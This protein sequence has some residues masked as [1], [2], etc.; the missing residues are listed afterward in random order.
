RTFCVP[1]G[2]FSWRRVAKTDN[3]VCEM[4]YVVHE[5]FRTLQ[6]EGAQAGTPMV[7]V[8]FAGCNLWSGRAADRARDA[9]RT[10]AACP[11]YCDTEFV[12]GDKLDV[13]SLIERIGALPGPGWICFTG[14]EPALQLD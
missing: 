7:F 2:G 12:S 10:G 13:P 1:A 11:L 3:R 5:V 8:R 4:A 6:G 14:G 9:A